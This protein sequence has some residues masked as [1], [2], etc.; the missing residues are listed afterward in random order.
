L[1]WR[2]AGRYPQA[3]RGN[4]CVVDGEPGYF[5][6]LS[7]VPACIAPFLHILYVPCPGVF[8]GKF[9]PAFPFCSHI[10]L[11][12]HISSG[13]FLGFPDFA[14]DFFKIFNFRPEIFF[15]FSTFELKKIPEISG[16]REL[17]S[18]VIYDVDAS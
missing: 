10:F 6:Y 13:K 1:G 14:P 12:V 11:A 18:N 3:N 2:R 5:A 7:T 8:S 4:Y 17:Q 15:G 16:T 9:F